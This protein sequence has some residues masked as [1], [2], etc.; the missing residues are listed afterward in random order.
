MKSGVPKR[1]DSGKKIIAAGA[2]IVRQP[3]YLLKPPALTGLD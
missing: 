1:S 3:Y 2:A